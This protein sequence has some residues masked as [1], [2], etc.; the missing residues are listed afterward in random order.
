MAGD[1]LDR[2]GVSTFWGVVPGSNQIVLNRTVLP[3]SR[4]CHGYPTRLPIQRKQPVCS[5]CRWNGLPVHPVR[6]VPS[7]LASSLIIYVDT[8]LRFKP[9]WWCTRNYRRYNVCLKILTDFTKGVIRERQQELEGSIP[10]GKKAFL[11]MLLEMKMENN[12]TDE[13]IRE[14][15]D[16]FMFEGGIMRDVLES[17][18]LGHDTTT[19]GIAWTLWCLACHPE[20]Q[21]EV[22]REMEAVFGKWKSH[23]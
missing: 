2:R 5:R 6:D 17:R 21:E 14:E 10:R 13:D 16:T 1:L 22:Y 20:I 11:D 23:S 3:P 18:S 8:C 9:Y 4:Y 19:T 7:I 15:V 12:L